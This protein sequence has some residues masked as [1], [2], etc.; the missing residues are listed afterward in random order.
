MVFPLLGLVTAGLSA[1]GSVAGA[2]GGSKTQKTTTESTVD[3]EKMVKSA[4]AAGFNPL[5][6]IRNGGSAGFST[7]TTTSPG[8]SAM[9][10]V[11]SSLGGFL[12]DAFGNQIDPLAK[13]RRQVDTALV[14]SQ[15][16]GVRSGG[17][18][19]GALYPGA[20]VYGPKVKAAE[21][22]GKSGPR[23]NAANL[24]RM[25]LNKSAM[26]VGAGKDGEVLPVYQAYMGPDGKHVYTDNN[27]FP[28]AEQ[29]VSAA[30][31]G[32]ANSVDSRLRGL[33]GSG[34][35]QPARVYSGRAEPQP[36]VRHPLKG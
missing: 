26:Y 24:V 36:Q 33:F 23:R 22:L 30:A 28:D 16:R 10:G 2:I 5:T 32:V 29:A 4:T 3:Y 15:L 11:L 12:G 9:P 25:G 27:N 19:A 13:A 8:V 34:Q 6:A 35:R 31:Y 7:S 1:A 14:D 20:S 17:R 21:P 18:R